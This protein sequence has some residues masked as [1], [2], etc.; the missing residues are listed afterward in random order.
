V[1]QALIIAACF[2][3]PGVMRL[4]HAPLATKIVFT[5]AHRKIVT[6]VIARIMKRPAFQI[7]GNLDFQQVVTAATSLRILIGIARI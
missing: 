1:E 3:L 6:V 5:K 2:R 4:H 7:I